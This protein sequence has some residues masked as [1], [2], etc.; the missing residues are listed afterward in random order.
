MSGAIVISKP[1]RAVFHRAKL[2]RDATQ[3]SRAWR[4]GWLGI[5]LRPA[6]LKVLPPRCAGEEP[7]CCL[8]AAG[9]SCLPQLACRPSLPSRRRKVVSIGAA[10]R[11]F[12]HNPTR[13]R[14][15]CALTQAVIGMLR[16]C[17]LEP[18]I[19][20]SRRH[21]DGRPRVSI[22]VLGGF[23]R[24]PACPDAQLFKDRG[25]EPQNAVMPPDRRQG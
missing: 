25:M 15:T 16:V 17:H 24:S 18:R 3:G 14:A 6:G 1:A 22:R 23:V 13:K 2:G 10:L 5:N 12:R 4:W 11:L 9:V 7:T 21:L 19:G 8:P 20:A